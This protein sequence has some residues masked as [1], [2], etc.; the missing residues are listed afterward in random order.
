MNTKKLPIEKVPKSESE[1]ST[2]TLK[3]FVLQRESDT[4]QTSGCGVVAEGVEF[5]N[6]QVAIHW[7]SQLESVEILANAR[8]LEKIHGHK[9]ATKIVWIDN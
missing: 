9:G 2:P 1:A 5:S 6:G 7:L 3:R 4:S 8:V